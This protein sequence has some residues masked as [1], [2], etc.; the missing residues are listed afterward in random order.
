MLRRPRLLLMVLDTAING[1]AAQRAI[2]IAVYS[3]SMMDIAIETC[4]FEHYTT[5]HPMTSIMQ[6]VLDLTESGLVPCSVPQPHA[7]AALTNTSIEK[8]LPSRGVGHRI[9]P[10]SR[11]PLR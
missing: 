3:D 8:V 5:E 7:K 1:I 10:L 6:P 4:S 2:D 11:V 9:R